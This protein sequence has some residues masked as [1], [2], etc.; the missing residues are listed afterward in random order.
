MQISRAALVGAVH[1]MALNPNDRLL[2]RAPKPSRSKERGCLSDNARKHT[3]MAGII[4]S[5]QR[6]PVKLQSWSKCKDRDA[7]LRLFDLSCAANFGA[8]IAAF[9]S[10][11]AMAPRPLCYPLMRSTLHHQR[12]QPMF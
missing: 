12:S 11:Q 3:K 8:L 5:Y 4:G 7:K 10:A 9:A 1:G 2:S 6:R